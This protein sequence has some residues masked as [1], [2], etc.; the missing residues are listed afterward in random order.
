MKS[1]LPRHD[2][3]A[4]GAAAAGSRT[5]VIRPEMVVAA[6]AFHLIDGGQAVGV[7]DVTARKTLARLRRNGFNAF[8]PRVIWE[9]MTDR[10]RLEWM[11]AVSDTVTVLRADR[12]AVLKRRRG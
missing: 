7:D 5:I 10:E 8:V 11:L 9:S 3:L 12:V 6:I 1:H 4:G 2:E